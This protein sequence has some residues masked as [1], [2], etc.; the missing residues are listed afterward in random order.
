MNRCSLP[1]PSRAS[2]LPVLLPYKPSLNPR[3]TIHHPTENSLMVSPILPSHIT[4]TTLFLVLQ[5]RTLPTAQFR[6]L[7]G[8]NVALHTPSPSLLLFPPNPPPQRL[9]EELATSLR[10]LASSFLSS[11][12]SEILARSRCARGGAPSRRR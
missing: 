4:T 1:L 9:T 12:V 8:N 6:H 3:K 7:R 2:N 5:A 10:P 11:L